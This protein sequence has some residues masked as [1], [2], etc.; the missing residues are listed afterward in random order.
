M[1]EMVANIST[2]TASQC[3][4][5]L[6][7][8]IINR[9]KE[10]RS[11]ATDLSDRDCVAYESLI[12]AFKLPKSD[13]NNRRLRRAAI[14]RAAQEAARVPIQV[15]EL[16]TEVIGLCDELEPLANTNL[17]SDRIGAASLACS[18]I[19]ICIMNVM[20][21]IPFISNDDFVTD[22]NSYMK[23]CIAYLAE[24]KPNSLPSELGR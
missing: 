20:A 24:H 15:A 13:A 3:H 23:E 10:I 22:L 6:H 4:G 7:S 14:N 17:T 19:H 11:K 2:E 1:I 21:N 12:S 16:A 9:A 18:T 8:A 5:K